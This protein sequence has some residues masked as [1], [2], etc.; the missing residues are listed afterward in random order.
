MAGAEPKRKSVLASRASLIGLIGRM[1]LI[2]LARGVL[3]LRSPGHGVQPPEGAKLELL[4][5][6][7]P[8]VRCEF[9]RPHLPII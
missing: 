3:R 1:G 8:V 9:A 7:T 5:G 4:N 2:G 6:E